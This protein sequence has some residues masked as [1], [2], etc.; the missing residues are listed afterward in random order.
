VSRLHKRCVVVLWVFVLLF[1]FETGYHS[2]DGPQ[3]VILSFLVPRCW[4]YKYV[5]PWPGDR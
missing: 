5:P 1:L 3:L 2:D 4:D